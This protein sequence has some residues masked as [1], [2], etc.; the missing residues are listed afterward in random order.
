MDWSSAWALKNFKAAWALACMAGVAL[1]FALPR[2]FGWVEARPGHRPDDP[3]LKLWGP[4]DLSLITFLV[5]YG[6]IAWVLFQVARRPLVVLH[7]LWAY[8]AMVLLRM[9]AMGTITLEPPP[10]ILPLADPV[11]EQFYPGAGP[12]LKDLFFSGHT[13]T[14]VLMALMAPKGPARWLAMAATVL[15][16]ALVLVQHVHWT[17][18]VLAAIPAAWAAWWAAGAVLGWFGL[19]D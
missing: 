16:G 9:V 13:A 17:V 6:T 1:M 5:L 19:R 3:L 2:F 8:I 15:V 4:A 18:D 10:D 7:G 12:F 14:M 11:T